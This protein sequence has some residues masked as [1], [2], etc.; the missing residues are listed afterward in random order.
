MF[1]RFARCFFLGLL[2]RLFQWNNFYT[3]STFRSSAGLQPSTGNNVGSTRVGGGPN[4]LPETN[5]SHLKHWGWKTTFLLGRPIFRGDGSFGEG[6]VR[7]A[8][9]N[10]DFLLGI[11][12]NV[13]GRE[14]C[15]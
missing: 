14:G 11:V 1:P 5:S 12:I 15:S 9:L 2:S 10:L 7:P 6:F 13:P 4:T 3:A 8:Q